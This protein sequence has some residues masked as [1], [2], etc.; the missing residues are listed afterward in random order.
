MSLLVGIFVLSAIIFLYLGYR[1]EYNL[2]RPSLGKNLPLVSIL[3]PAYNS[4][5]TIAR[6][7]KSALNLDYLKKEIL[8]V[9]DS[10]DNTS[11]ICKALGVRY[12]QNK[13][14][15]GKS[16]ALNEAVKQTKG[17]ILFFLDA[18]T[19]ARKDSLRKL[20]PWFK[21]NTAAVVP[22]YIAQNPKK[23]ITK[24]VS[25]ENSFMSSLFKIH[26]YFGSMIAFRGCGVA[27]KKSV[28]ESLDGWPRTQME[29][30][31]FAA[32]LVKSGYKI[33]YEPEAIVETKEA[34]SIREL[35]RQRMRWGK[36]AFYTFWSHKGGYKSNKQFLVSTLPYTFLGLCILAFLFVQGFY[37]IPALS[38]VASTDQFTIVFIFLIV[39]LL[40]NFFAT[41]ATGTLGH[42]ALLTF[43]ENKKSSIKDL[44][45]LVPF[46]FLY[47]P[48]ILYFYVRGILSG[49][50]DKIQRR[51]P[52]DFKYW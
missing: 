35:G 14:R 44:A 41:V 49:I 33:Q 46:I 28:F 39:P 16:V 13:T 4:E 6:V 7:I 15:L 20:I 52:L 47:I 40:T 17:S 12:I 32:V 5:K 22:K 25:I 26:M 38:F 1:W 37:L 36:G 18:D 8:V 48:T 19:V 24:L 9:N 42:F 2:K 21:G 34:E 3:I 51:D 23:L 45:Y 27:I 29:D 30:N 43:S 10:Q 50:S 31:D 11:K